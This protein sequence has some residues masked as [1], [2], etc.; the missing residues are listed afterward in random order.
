M[1][2]KL[3]RNLNQSEWFKGKK[4]GKTGQRKPRK[5]KNYSKMPSEQYLR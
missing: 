4:L 5:A 1:V 3:D 2:G